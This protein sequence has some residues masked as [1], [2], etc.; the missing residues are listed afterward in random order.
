MPH[1]PHETFGSFP[2]GPY[3]DDVKRGF[4]AT[5]DVLLEDDIVAEVVSLVEA[6]ADARTR[7]V[8][9]DSAAYDTLL[10]STRTSSPPS[11]SAVSRT[12][13]EL[14]DSEQFAL[15]HGVVPLI[16]QRIGDGALVLDNG[17]ILDSPSSSPLTK[18]TEHLSGLSSADKNDQAG[19][20]SLSLE[21]G[22]F[23]PRD[24][25]TV[26]LAMPATGA[27]SNQIDDLVSTVSG[28]VHD[29][30]GAPWMVTSTEPDPDFFTLHSAPAG[31]YAGPIGATFALGIAGLA[32]TSAERAFRTL[33]GRFLESIHE[34]LKE[35]RQPGSGDPLTL[36]G[37]GCLG[38]LVALA[39]IAALEGDH[40]TL[41]AIS[42]LAG[43]LSAAAAPPR[44]LDLIDGASGVAIGMRRLATLTRGD[45]YLA[46]QSR[47]VEDLV[48]AMPEVLTEETPA[49]G[50]AHGLSGFALALHHAATDLDLPDL[51]VSAQLCLELEDELMAS[52]RAR[53]AGSSSSWCWGATG[54]LT[55]R[56]A[57]DPDSPRIDALRD[58]V[59]TTR[60]DQVGICH[61]VAG[62]ALLL[63]AS[64]YTRRFGN[65]DA[66]SVPS[67]A[68][69]LR[70][71]PRA[72]ANAP[73]FA[74]D[75]GLFTG[76]AG[77][78]VSLCA[79][80]DG[81]TFSLHDLSYQT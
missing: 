46:A 70:A 6:N 81:A 65:R 75:A 5:Y 26:A 41:D 52:G 59:R 22:A 58:I 68:S 73:L 60:S 27:L 74:R 71:R 36:T 47:A 54:Q 30:E 25:R 9:A 10:Q 55:A 12:Q 44:G 8:I 40:G 72:R 3:L 76:V 19:L 23:N 50:L 77:V 80:R 37:P 51:H 7:I 16:E 78:L 42:A 69:S 64:A 62:P 79:F 4:H 33:S 57:C 61:G 1:Q 43:P 31:L 45:G 2:A 49:V 28:A 39:S 63:R 14:F 17:R 13:K 11:S 20:L 15:D 56:L 38:P 53:E 18:L 66:A 48:E 32:H 35:R 24:A 34:T 67:W 21:L 29:H